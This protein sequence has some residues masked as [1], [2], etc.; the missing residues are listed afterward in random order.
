MRRVLQQPARASGIFACFQIVPAAGLLRTEDQSV[1]F[2]LGGTGK[3]RQG[4]E[5]IQRRKNEYMASPHN[6]HATLL[7]VA[8]HFAV[9]DMAQ[10][11]AFYGQLGFQATYN[12]GNFAIVER[13]GVSLHFNAFSDPQRA[14]QSVGSQ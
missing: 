1:R 9:Q 2:H 14:T 7:S 12:D 4:G 5:D 13:D 3:E 10:A 6:R 11:L 8:P